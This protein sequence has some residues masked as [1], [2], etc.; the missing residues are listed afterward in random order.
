MRERSSEV[1]KGRMHEGRERRIKGKSKHEFSLR[2][3]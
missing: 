2:R 3:K 1:R